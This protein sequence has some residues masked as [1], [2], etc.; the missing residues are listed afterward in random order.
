VI[1]GGSLEHPLWRAPRREEFLAN[2]SKAP[3]REHYDP[4]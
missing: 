4:Y 2:G 3:S 1:P